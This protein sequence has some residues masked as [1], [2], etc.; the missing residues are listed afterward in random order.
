MPD[1]ISIPDITALYTGLL[2][3][4]GIG[5]GFVCGSLRGKLKINLG[6]GGNADMLLA[7]R[8]QANFVEYVPMALILIALAEMN[9][10]PDYAVHGFGLVLLAARV[11]HAFGLSNESGQ[12]LFR[13]LGAAVTAL[14]T[15]VA[16]IWNIYLFAT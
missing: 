11:S 13:G 5:I 3:I 14:V 7:M 9:G 4:L 10:A 2:A 6:D 8:R 12:I 1:I 16:A 15:V